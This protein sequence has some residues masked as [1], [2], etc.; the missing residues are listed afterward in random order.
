MIGIGA[1]VSMISFGTGMQ[2]NVTAAFEAS[3]LFNTLMVMPGGAEVPSG[4]PDEAGRRDGPRPRPEER[5]P[6]STPRPWPRSP[7]SQGVRTAYPD[8][9]IPALGQP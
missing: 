7:G 1:L 4:D 2:K 8:V 5:T 6:F 9:N 3:D